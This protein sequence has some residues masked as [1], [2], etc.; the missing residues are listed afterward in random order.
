MSSSF[1]YYFQ[2]L[3][4]DRNVPGLQSQKRKGQKITRISKPSTNDSESYF[5]GRA[6]RKK[7]LDNLNIDPRL[8]QRRPQPQLLQQIQQRVPLP[9]PRQPDPEPQQYQPPSPSPPSPWQQERVPSPSPRQPDPPLLREH[10]PHD[11]PIAEKRP[12][13]TTSTPQAAASGSSDPF[14]GPLTPSPNA[15]LKP[16]KAQ[17]HKKDNVLVAKKGSAEDQRIARRSTRTRKK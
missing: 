5:K 9:S 1:Y 14:S 7:K 11:A 16:T 12:R 4:I 13:A 15:S 6:N 2:T 3:T 10:Q 17:K 8:L